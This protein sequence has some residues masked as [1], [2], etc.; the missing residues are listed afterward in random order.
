MKTRKTYNV[1]E[2]VA[3]KVEKNA[4][5]EGRSNSDIANRAL[6]KQLNVKL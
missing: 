4:K 2:K 3:D 5:K 1:D 6:A